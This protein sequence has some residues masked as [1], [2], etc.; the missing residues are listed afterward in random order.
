MNV[1]GLIVS[2]IA[3]LIVVLLIFLTRE[4]SPKI[5]LKTETA[6]TAS[7][8]D[9]LT[10]VE[11]IGPKIQILLESVG[12]KTY[13]DL[14]QADVVKLRKIML[15]HNLRIADPSTW[16]KQSQLLVEGK[17]DELKKYQDTL[18]GGRTV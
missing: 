1:V 12:I 7:K 17:L 4:S 10:K 5:G 8:V 2:I 15:E 9:D 14:A 13:G 11:G 6:Q 18:K 16:P 3:V